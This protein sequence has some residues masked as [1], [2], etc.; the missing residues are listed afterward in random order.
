M[1]DD[2]IDCRRANG[3]RRPRDA[4]VI[5]LFRNRR[6][7]IKAEWPKVKCD[8]T[9]CIL[10]GGCHLFATAVYRLWPKQMHVSEQVRSGWSSFRFW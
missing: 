9:Y 5:L 6:S 7:K 3:V 4:G 10:E 2:D 1:L 8:R